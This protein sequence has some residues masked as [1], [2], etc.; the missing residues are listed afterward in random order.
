M[1]LPDFA[2]VDSEPARYFAPGERATG[3][4]PGD[5]L[6][7]RADD[8]Q[9]RF[10]RWGQRLRIRGDDRVF[11]FWDHAALIVGADEIV[12]VVAGSPVHLAPLSTYENQPVA[13]VRPKCSTSDLEQAVAFGRWA[14]GQEYGVLTLV[15]IVVAHFTGSKI[16]FNF[17]DQHI[18]SGL[19]ARA[20][21]RTGAI[22]NRPP[23]H[24]APADLAKY[25]GV[26]PPPGMS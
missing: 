18:C 2:P 3:A 24:I 8:F 13:I 11:T 23:S 6:L 4:Q 7:T 1:Q 5:F 19:V 21:E 10:I 25:Y 20:M 26:V 17:A 22:F 12:E 15:S 9:G 14:V 16:A